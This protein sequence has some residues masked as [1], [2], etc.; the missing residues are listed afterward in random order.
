MAIADGVGGAPG[1]EK[2]AENAIDT[3]RGSG[4]EI[5]DLSAVFGKI[6]IA[7][8]RYSSEMPALAR[9]ATTLSVV[10][11]EGKSSKACTR[12]RHAALSRA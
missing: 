5:R 2:A 7:I 3:L 10:S 9:M 8:R 6:V 11:L 4:D 12:W 1:G